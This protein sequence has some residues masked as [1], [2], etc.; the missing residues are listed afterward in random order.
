MLGSIAKIL[1]IAALLLL[2]TSISPLVEAKL[3]TSLKD[4]AK[5]RPNQ[6]AEILTQIESLKAAMWFFIALVLSA[7]VFKQD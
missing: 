7:N 6:L 2:M 4:Y 3:A 1:S 5:K